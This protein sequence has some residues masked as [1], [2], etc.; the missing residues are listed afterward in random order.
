MNNLKSHSQSDFK[1]SHQGDTNSGIPFYFSPRT[2]Q[3]K[4]ARYNSVF[5]K[6]SFSKSATYRP[7]DLPTY[8]ENISQNKKQT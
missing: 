7:T 6:K 8:L 4:K 2:P 1:I 3:L 5:Y